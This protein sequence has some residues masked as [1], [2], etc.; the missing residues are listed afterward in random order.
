MGAAHSGKAPFQE[1]QA[2]TRA[3]QW[4]SAFNMPAI[5]FVAALLIVWQLLCS[6]EIVPSYLLPS[7]FAVVKA[8]IT[9]ASLLWQNAWYTLCEA[10][11]GLL[12]GS[13]LGFGL[14][15]LQDRFLFLHRALH[16]LITISQTIPTVAI[17][18]VL[19]LWLGYDMLPK[20]VLVT[21]TTFFPV[22]ISLM[23]GFSS[24]DPDLLDLMRTM[25]ATRRQ[26]L[27]YVKLPSARAAF[28]SGLE[29]SATYAVVGAVIAEWL[30]GFNGLGVFMTRVRKSYAYDQMFAAI[31]VISLLSLALMAF[32]RLLAKRSNPRNRRRKKSAE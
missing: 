20:I 11:L 13:L 2:A 12:F 28:F 21:I 8:L 31:L 25:G 6:F 1:S 23:Q 16:P 5:L 32:I 24:V 18:P 4:R 27:F 3:T 15:L 22:S 14:A 9:D 30:G 10:L 26:I 17:A 29:I 19:V 7:P